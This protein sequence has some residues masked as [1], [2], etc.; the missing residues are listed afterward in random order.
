MKTKPKLKTKNKSTPAAGAVPPLPPSIQRAIDVATTRAAEAAVASRPAAPAH[1]P[2]TGQDMQFDLSEPTR[3]KMLYARLGLRMKSAY[4]ERANH[5]GV[6]KQ[7]EVYKKLGDF[8][9][10]TKSLGQLVTALELG[11]IFAKE[12]VSTELVELTRPNSILLAAGIRTVS[13]YGTSLTI[14]SIDD[15]VQVYWVGEG[16][17]PERSGVKTG[18][19]SLQSHKLMARGRISN[20]LLRLGTMDA[21]ALI[22]QDMAAAIAL[23]VDVVGIK[24][25]GGKKPKGLRG[26][27]DQAQRTP[28]AGNTTPN[29]ITD[30]D[31]L[32]ATVSKANIPGG[33]RTNGGFYYS[34][35]DAFTALKQTRDNAGWVFPELRNAEKP[36][37]N[38]CP[39]FTTESVAGD[40]V[41][42]FGLASQL[43]LGEA[44]PLE[45]T[46]GEDGT[47]FSSDMVT[48]R[49]ITHVDFLLRYRKA[50]AEKTNVN[51]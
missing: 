48:M 15:G 5:F 11:G 26:Q 38:G 24:G 41:L 22:G 39:F 27:M 32:L 17:P 46:M 8:L 44:T 43:I 49:G 1:T 30:T 50:F 13:G 34:D 47:D 33:I 31:G 20:D 37:L 6:S 14:G 21:A 25:E 2:V 10:R 12:T 36:T 42:G 19:L 35:I 4:L 3:Q 23:E 51:Y 29:K 16:E 45:V 18:A 40:K 9:T 28:T 7:G